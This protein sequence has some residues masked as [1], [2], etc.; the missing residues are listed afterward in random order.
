MSARF[1]ASSIRTVAVLGAGTMGHGIAHVAAL[2]GHDVR[3][4]DVT[5]ELADAGRGKIVASL[6][7]GVSLGKVQA[8]V[9]DAAIARITATGD[10]AAACTGADLV[11]EAVPEKLELKR[12]LF[13]AVERAAPATALYATNTSSLP[14]A[15]IAG[16]VGD[17]S[18]MIGMHFFNPVH[19]MKLLE[20]VHHAASDPSAVA[21]AVALGEAWGKTAIVVKDS[22]G[23]ASSRLG[24]TLGLEAIRMVEEGVASAADIDTAMKLGYGHPMGPLELT[25]LVGLDVRLGIADYLS[26]ALGP[27]FEPPEL[28]R[29]KVAEG[30]LG[31]KSGEGF[32]TWVDGKRR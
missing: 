30:K 11:V 2:A 1:S 13:A 4:Y 20:V 16:A 21:T 7:K 9:R 14:V 18:R 12:E 23:F 27:T 5:Q 3:L 22:P 31:K 25:D 8:D 19:L 26:D 28:L 10:L 24:L 32:Y 29:K 15:K 17:P 6:D